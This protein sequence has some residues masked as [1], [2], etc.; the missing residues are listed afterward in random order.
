MY[1]RFYDTFPPLF[2]LKLGAYKCV[3]MHTHMFLDTDLWILCYRSESIL[4]LGTCA[5][6]SLENNAAAFRSEIK[7]CYY[8]LYSIFLCHV[9]EVLM[10][11]YSQ[12]MRY[13]S[14]S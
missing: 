1:I 13:C 9:N 6:G 8:I 12:G 11:R 3:H 4:C 2:R 10:W 5:N 14:S 7:K